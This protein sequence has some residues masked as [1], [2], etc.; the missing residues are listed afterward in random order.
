MKNRKLIAAVLLIAVLCLACACASAA[1]CGGRFTGGFGSFI[2]TKHTEK[3]EVI[4][5]ATHLH[6][7]RVIHEGVCDEEGPHKGKTSWVTIDSDTGSHQW[8]NQGGNK[9]TTTWK[10]TVCNYVYGTTNNTDQEKKL[11]KPP[12]CAAEGQYWWHFIMHAPDG[13]TKPYAV[14]AEKVPAT[15]IHTYDSGKETTK[16][17]CVKEG[18]KT[19]TCT[20]CGNT[21]TEKI[22]AT[23]KH[24]YDNGTVTTQPTCGKEGVKTFKCLVCG[25]TKTEKVPATGNH[26]WDNGAVIREASAEHSGITRYTCK[27]CK[28]TKDVYSGKLSDTEG[29][30]SGAPG[31]LTGEGEGAGAPGGLT[32]EGEECRHEHT[33]TLDPVDPTC[34]EEGCTGTTVCT[35]CGEIIE[36][37]EIIPAKGH[38]PAPADRK[39][40]TADED[41]HEEGVVCSECGEIISGCETIEKTGSG[42]DDSDG[43]GISDKRKDADPDDDVIVIKDPGLP[44]YVIIQT[45]SGDSEK[46][47]VIKPVKGR[48][49]D[50]CP[51][52]DDDMSEWIDIGEGR[53]IRVCMD[54]DCL[55]YEIAT[56]PLFTIT[57]DDT[58]YTI[59]PICGTFSGEGDF[60]WI[61]GVNCS[62]DGNM[63]YTFGKDVPFGAVEAVI[64]DYSDEPVSI[65]NA[66]TVIREAKGEMA[67]FG[68][69]ATVMV[70]YEGDSDVTLIRMTI[71]GIFTE[72]AGGV[73]NGYVIFG[74]D[75]NGLYLLVK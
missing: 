47:I 63:L 74:T 66:F 2:C 71:D 24:T 18:V 60:A 33:E 4:S 3:W 50:K 13:S 19:Y 1:G 75:D 52:C 48:D 37:G 27:V 44:G 43:D 22:P 53:H 46:Q 51:W 25:D 29:T 14:P 6:H 62:V 38:T 68:P 39:E 34:E 54:P 15:G 40:P 73:K 70:P 61:E 31:G 17:T 32:G 56:C 57:V 23:G 67:A 8:T 16:P 35:E 10:C 21:K 20:V 12:T 49:G 72:L 45:G 11:D 26:A 42:D 9:D 64:R 55:Y 41:G 7:K 65:V 58:V 36:G 59:D 30:S 5:E 28:A 69:K